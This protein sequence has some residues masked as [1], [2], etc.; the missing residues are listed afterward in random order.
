MSRLRIALDQIIGVR[1]YTLGLLNSIDEK[2]W[3]RMPAPAVSHIAWQAGHLA[4]A[5]YRLL[6]EFIRGTRPSDEEVIPNYYAVRFLFG[7]TSDPHP[8]ASKYPQ[9]AQI[10][11]VLD[12]VHSQVLKEIPEIPDGELDQPV[13]AAHPI[14]TTKFS[15]LIW[16]AQ[17]EMLHTGQI[18]LLRRLLGLPPIW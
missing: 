12:R 6:I 15:S 10:K 14:V 13:T 2:D 18:G 16:A 8:D 1:R 3:F 11:A 9:P 17:H 7:R 4:V 5:Q